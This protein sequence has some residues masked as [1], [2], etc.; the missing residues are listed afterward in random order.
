M[1]TDDIV[2]KLGEDIESENKS[3]LEDKLEISDMPLCKLL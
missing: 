2:K 1:V 3:A